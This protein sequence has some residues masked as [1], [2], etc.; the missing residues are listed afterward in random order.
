MK[1]VF[2]TISAFLNLKHI[3]TSAVA[4]KTWDIFYDEIIDFKVVAGVWDRNFTCLN[5]TRE[6][7]T[8]GY[9]IIGDKN[10]F[11]QTPWSCSNKRIIDGLRKVLRGEQGCQTD[12]VCPINRLSPHKERHRLVL[13]RFLFHGSGLLMG[14]DYPSYHANIIKGSHKKPACW[15][16]GK[17]PFARTILA[18]RYDRGIVWDSPLSLNWERIWNYFY[19]FCLSNGFGVEALLSRCLPLPHH[20]IFTLKCPIKFVLVPGVWIDRNTSVLSFKY[21][22]IPSPQL[23]RAFVE[24]A[25][26][27]TLISKPASGTVRSEQKEGRRWQKKR[28]QKRETRAKS[29]KSR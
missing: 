19:G 26:Y 24:S 28:C 3:S 17:L 1:W 29:R 2:Y 23:P 18:D 22:V 13:S 14:Y 25:P 11:S 12:A 27:L 5:E 8:L 6:I 9:A 10:W 21:R 4:N 7:S 20:S 16:F 15:I